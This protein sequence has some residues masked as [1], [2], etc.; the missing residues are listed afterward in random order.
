MP[1]NTDKQARTEAMLGELA[2]LALMVSRDLA[3]RARESED[4]QEA[5]ALAQAFQKTSRVVRLTLALSFKLDRDAA[6]DALEEAR[7]AR[8]EQAQAAKAE[9]QRA[10]ARLNQH[11]GRV[12]A[13]FERLIWA[14]TED[15]DEASDL[16]D[17]LE[18]RLCEESRASRRG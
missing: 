10:T 4:A 9:A 14:E 12:R 15:E 13:R 18:A 7:A 3:V 16:F 5:A 6:R 2:E 8:D 1:R 11:M 17:E